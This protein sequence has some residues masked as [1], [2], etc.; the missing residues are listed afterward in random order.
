VAV[1]AATAVTVADGDGA[2]Y[3]GAVP[4]AVAARCCFTSF[5]E[6]ADHN[7]LF[8]PQTLEALSSTLYSSGL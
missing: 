7:D 5:P 1:S 4:E 2:V 8:H 6:A 3:V